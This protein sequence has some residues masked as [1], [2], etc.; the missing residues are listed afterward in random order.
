LYLFSKKLA[1]FSIIF[2][3]PIAP[4]LHEQLSFINRPAV[5][6]FIATPGID[7]CAAFIVGTVLNNI[8]R[9][10][11]PLIKAEVVPWPVA[12]TLIII[13]VSIIVAITRNIMQTGQEFNF[14]IL[15]AKLL[16]YKLIAR[17]DIYVPLVDIFTFSVC[18]LLIGILINFL[19]KNKDSE[20]TF[21]KALTCTLYLSA[22][23][24][25]FQSITRFGLVP[26][27]YNH[28]ANSLFYGAHGFQPDLHAF[29][30]L[31]LIGAVGLLGYF[32]YAST[33]RAKLY[34]GGVII[35]SWIALLLSKSRASIAF[36]LVAGSIFI[37][38]K[39]IKRKGSDP[40][41]NYLFIICFVMVG[42]TALPLIVTSQFVR[43]IYSSEYLNFD[44]WNNT[45]SLRPDF[46][47]AAVRMFSDFPWFGAGQ[48]NFLRTSS[49]AVFRYSETLVAWGGDNAHNYFLQTLA[50]LGVIG[51]FS[52]I[53]MFLW[54]LFFIK[55]SSITPACVIIV[56]IFLGNIYSHSL[57]VRENLFVLA[58][59]VALTYSKVKWQKKR[60]HPIE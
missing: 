2:L 7:I 46:H 56:A 14:E 55:N 59:V 57:I 24:G 58:I 31:M 52:F 39:V 11:K 43:D 15:I 18:A 42:I 33:N 44:L 13:I 48:G 3:L 25:I 23:W 4:A 49:D 38:L 16:L 34:L 35:L 22:T 50:E 29:G 1:F 30:A 37:I 51:V 26:T 47:R 27:T 41:Y 10:K 60:L 54:P 8:A 5:P 28:R 20:K 12:T 9:Y 45:L 19:K 6:F 17:G 36:A 32:F 40:F 53:G 21:V